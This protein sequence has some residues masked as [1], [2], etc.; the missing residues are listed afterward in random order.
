[1]SKQTLSNLPLGWVLPSSSNSSPLS[2]A[3]G[4][5]R[6][7][8]SVPDVSLRDERYAVREAQRGDTGRPRRRSRPVKYSDSSEVEGSDSQILLD[9]DA[10]A[11]RK[12]RKA[13]AGARSTLGDGWG[14][15]ERSK[16][17]SHREWSP[18]RA[19]SYRRG[20][21]GAAGAQDGQREKRA[22]PSGFLAL[23]DV[24]WSS[25]SGGPALNGDGQRRQHRRS[26]E[27]VDVQPK[28][29]QEARSSASS[30]NT[31]VAGA[32]GVGKDRVAAVK[33]EESEARAGTA[34]TEQAGAPTGAALTVGEVQH[35]VQENTLQPVS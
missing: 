30:E 32:N 27:A 14:V 11:R 4:W 28:S 1:M 12:R 24:D 22:P 9:G 17:N 6:Q 34:T 29:L 26:L 5:Q 20:E 19:Q 3:T 10:G 8:A 33:P 23:S 18:P 7:P 13:D 35:N 21:R 25:D 15:A 2:C 31:D 16:W